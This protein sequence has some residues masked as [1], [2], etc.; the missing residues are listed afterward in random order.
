MFLKR[1]KKAKKIIFA[2]GV[3]ALLIISAFCVLL[4]KAAD[5]YASGGI[6]NAL[7]ER[8]NDIFAENLEKHS[9]T[10]KSAFA[11]EKENGDVKSVTVETYK[12]NRFVSD[13]A[14]D[15]AICIEN[16]RHSFYLPIGNAFN[17]RLLSGIGPRIRFTVIPL[18]S[19]TAYIDSSMT[20][21]GINQNL[22]RAVLRLNALVNLL[23]PFG[24]S[25][26]SIELEYVLC[27]IL[28]VGKVPELY[29][30]R[31]ATP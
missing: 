13:M 7:I 17:M 4:G 30:S 14:A 28:I 25:E 19:V 3:F 31:D 29:F 1:K 12:L 22:Y 23:S 15:T 11:A 10:L 5:E 27:E 20:S 21:A 24:S 9:D 8:F 16:C 2:V 18:G 6:K 26:I